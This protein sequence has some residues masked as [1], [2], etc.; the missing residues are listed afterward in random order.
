MPS[1]PRGPAYGPDLTTTTASLPTLQAP[2]V[3][4]LASDPLTLASDGAVRADRLAEA[5]AEQA[6]RL[7]RTA[8]GATAER[9]LPPTTAPARR[10]PGG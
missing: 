8:A 4:A 9:R 10:R 7:A 3:G 5:A 1:K 6:D 2:P